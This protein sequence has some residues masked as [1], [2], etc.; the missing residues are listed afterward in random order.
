ISFSNGAS[1]TNSGSLLINVPLKIN[2]DGSTANSFT[3]IG[4]LTHNTTDSFGSMAS[5][6][7]VP[8]DNSGVI[9]VQRGS[10]TFNA[11]F[12]S[13]GT[14]TP[15]NTATVNLN[16]SLTL[17]GGLF[18]SSPPQY[19]FVYVS[20]AV[21]LT[22]DTTVDRLGVGGSATLTSPVIS[23]PAKLSAAGLAWY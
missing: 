3:N 20:T 1:F 9:S 10:I 18:G 19:G 16:S 5:T 7:N 11:P 2:T 14:L 21:T 23:G 8:F 15:G 12:T 22:N 13:S 17:S 4:T 6:I